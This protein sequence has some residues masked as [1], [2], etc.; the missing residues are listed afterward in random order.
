[1]S[2]CAWS[3]ARSCSRM[4]DSPRLALGSIVVCSTELRLGKHLS[5]RIFAAA[6]WVGVI[7]TLPSDAAS[8]LDTSIPTRTRR[9]IPSTSCA[10]LRA[11]HP[12]LAVP[13]ALSASAP[14]L[15]A[16]RFFSLCSSVNSAISNISAIYLLHSWKGYRTLFV[17]IA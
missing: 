3:S 16:A 6:T 8:S 13:R 15:P 12:F 17:R 7:S 9:R 5:I 14:F 1:M 2:G 10:S 11:V 4:S